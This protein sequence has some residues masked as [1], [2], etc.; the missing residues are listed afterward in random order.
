MSEK[1]KSDIH[2]ARWRCLLIAI[3][4]THSVPIICL[5]YSLQYIP[6]KPWREQA[7]T[8]K[9]SGVLKYVNH[10]LWS[11]INYLVLSPSLLCDITRPGNGVAQCVHYIQ[12]VISYCVDAIPL[13]WNEHKGTIELRHQ[14]H[15]YSPGAETS[16]SKYRENI[17]IWSSPFPIICD[18]IM[19]EW[20]EYIQITSMYGIHLW[21]MNS[22]LEN[23]VDIYYLNSMLHNNGL[24]LCSRGHI[25][26]PGLAQDESV[27]QMVSPA[28]WL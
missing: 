28:T 5:K 18:I 16:Y 17:N 21:Y 26:C 23:I 6:M 20:D 10:A 2:S 27:L 11:G 13:S 8:L 1:N 22:G 14:G 24:A 7:F 12:M 19:N 4:V 3:E 15:I 9:R 25:K